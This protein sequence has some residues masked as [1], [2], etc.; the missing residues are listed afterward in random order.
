M[1]V[2]FS[3]NF[4][5]LSQSAFCLTTENTG[6]SRRSHLAAQLEE[7]AGERLG[8]ALDVGP[9]P[10]Q[11]PL[12]VAHGLLHRDLRHHF[13]YLRRQPSHQP[14][15]WRGGGGVKKKRKKCSNQKTNQKKEKC[16]QT[17]K[18]KSPTNKKVQS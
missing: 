5:L 10:L 1:L 14:T 3:S 8:V 2:R 6:H 13:V 17:N 16:V 7:T 18:Q 11:V 12:L 15:C 4:A 9:G